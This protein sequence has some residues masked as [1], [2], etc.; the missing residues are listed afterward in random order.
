VQSTL[1]LLHIIFEETNKQKKK[2]RN[3]QEFSLFP[4]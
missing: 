1:L 4:P 3:Y 2:H